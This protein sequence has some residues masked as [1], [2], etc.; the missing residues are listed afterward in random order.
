MDTDALIRR[1]QTL[2]ALVT[3][4]AAEIARLHAFEALAASQADEIAR[5]GALLDEKDAQ[6]ALLQ[7][8]PHSDKNSR[9]SSLPPSSSYPA[10]RPTPPTPKKK[11]PPHGHPGKGRKQA[12]A[13][14]TLDCHPMHCAHC[15]ADLQAVPGRLY[16][17]SQLIELPPLLPQVIEARRYRCRCPECGTLNTAAYPDGWNPKQRFG[18]R[19]EA[20]LAYLHHQHHIGYERLARLL[21]ELWGLHVS[22]GA[23][24]NVLARVHARLGTHVEA[25]AKRVRESAVV[26]SDE[27]RARVAGQTCWNWVI[28]SPTAVYH[29]VAK[30]RGT[31]ELRDFFGETLPEVQESDC[32]AAQLASP[33]GTKQICQAHQLRE[34]LYAIEHADGEYA[35]RMHRLTRLAI[36]LSKRRDELRTELY[37]H[38]AA[39]LKRVADQVGFGALTANPFGEGLQRRYRRLREHWWVFLE[40][41]DV[42]PTNNRSEQALRPSVIHRKV[43]GGFRSEWGAVAYAGFLS[44]VQTLQREEAE[45]FPRLL[46]MLAPPASVPPAV[47]SGG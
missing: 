33:V 6:L 15:Q 28:Q 29:F 17:R 47:S 13:T 39:R 5:L 19:L 21:K 20:T 9:N 38:Q 18:P 30:S 35:A 32:Y 31:R 2:E 44:V 4:Q 23:L 14:V 46:A 22:Q 8:A 37:R 41:A 24:A 3:A 16:R 43:T 7:A 27:T 25:I 36:H 40:R 1:L 10:N 34:L 45:L 11:G 12:V 42:S 26:G